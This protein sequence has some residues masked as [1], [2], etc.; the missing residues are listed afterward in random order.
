MRC[1]SKKDA[2]NGAISTGGGSN[3]R[4]MTVTHHGVPRHG[5][6]AA[7]RRGRV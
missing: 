6:P 3:A 2:I 4:A 7:R 1:W 5:V